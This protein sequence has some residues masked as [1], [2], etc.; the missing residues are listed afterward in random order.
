METAGGSRAGIAGFSPGQATGEWEHAGWRQQRTPGAYECRHFNAMDSAGNGVSVSLYDGYCFHPYYVQ[1]FNRYCRR[2][3]RVK[4]SSVREQ[5]LPG[6]YPAAAISVF[7]GGKCVLRSINVFPPGAFHGEQ[8][9][10][11][12]LVGPNRVTLRQDGTLG[13]TVR[14]YPMENTLTGPRYRTS[15]SIHVDL[16]FA[17]RLTGYG[18]VLPLRPDSSDGARHGWVLPVPAASVTGR[19][20]QISL[21]DDTTLLNLPLEGLGCHDQ[22]FGASG[23]GRDINCVTRG[24]AVSQEWAI[25]WNHTGASRPAD[26]D[27]MVI[28]DQNAAPV[29]IQ[30]PQREITYGRSGNVLN[31]Y[32]TGMVLHG[33]DSRGNNV[34]L[35]IQ[36]QDI[37]ESSPYLVRNSCS[38]QLRAR[39]S[40]RYL[41]VGIM[42]TLSVRGLTWPIIS[43]LARRSILVVYA[44]DPLWR[45]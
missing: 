3:T 9:S 24:H 20:Q 22:Y 40:K 8:G 39:G 6:F 21:A 25:A 10:P 12:C 7:Q 30:N 28:F 31:Q 23:I 35:L 17:P 32:P 15:Q 42:E 41:G 43:D 5:V 1:E 26:T 44:D 27:S 37:I 13:L 34:E 2:S 14:G 18:Q 4:I 16:T 45:Q 38:V 29:I 11:E 36:H 19:I 33:S